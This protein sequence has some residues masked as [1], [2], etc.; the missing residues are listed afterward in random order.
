M[1]KFAIGV[2]FGLLL[3]LS[4]F[5]YATG[6]I[7]VDLFPVKLWLNGEQKKLPEEY[8]ILNYSGHAYVPIRYLTEQFGGKVSYDEREGAISVSSAPLP[9]LPDPYTYEMAERNG[10]LMKRRP[11]KKK[12]EAFVRSV[13]ED[14][15][16]W[17][18][19][20]SHTIEGDPLIV[21]LIY[22]SASKN[23]HY[24]QDRSR[25]RF[26]SMA[27]TAVTCKRLDEVKAG[28]GGSTYR[29]VGCDGY[30]REIDLISFDK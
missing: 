11:D 20:T 26:G 12:I 3:A 24:I 15:E 19:L 2:L 29:L 25:D 10:D 21:S 30:S 8:V 6:K 18:R 7:E 23:I 27:I 1:K 13:H 16:D 28:E 14:T 17:I 4:P 22:D 9:V 5:A